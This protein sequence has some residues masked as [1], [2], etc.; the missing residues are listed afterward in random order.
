MTDVSLADH[1]QARRR[2]DQLLR[3]PSSGAEYR[4][5]EDDGSISP[6]RAR[7]AACARDEGAAGARDRPGNRGNPPFEEIATISSTWAGRVAA[8]F[9]MPKGAKERGDR[10]ALGAM[11]HRLVRGPKSQARIRERLDAHS[12]PYDGP[13]EIL[14]GI[15]LDLC[16][17]SERYPAGVQ[18]PAE[19]REG[20]PYQPQVTQFK[21]SLEGT[22]L[23][24]P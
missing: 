19:Q 18:L 20:E 10:N 13:L 21:V 14:P 1:D 4:R 24:D 2:Q 6:R 3:R 15:F 9:E 11:Q 5:H 16:L 7:H 12:V 23:A 8:F 17:R 22:A